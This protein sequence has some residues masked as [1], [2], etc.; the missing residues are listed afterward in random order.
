MSQIILSINAGS[1]SLKVSVYKSNSPEPVQL[2][3]AQ[4][5]GLTAPPAKIKY[6]RGDVKIKGEEVSGV[7][8]QGTAFRQILDHLLSD[9][10]L[11]EVQDKESIKFACHRVV[12]G[13]DFSD[14]QLISRDI[15]KILERLSD[16]APL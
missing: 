3:E 12:H 15:F 1:S 6:S 9:D 10:G 7:N 2:A 16:L 4:I 8:D 5:D 11:P 14:S 13:G